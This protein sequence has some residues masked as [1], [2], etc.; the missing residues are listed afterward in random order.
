MSGGPKI[1]KEDLEARFRA[2]AGDVEQKKGDAQD[3]LQ[4]VAI[5]GGVL[6]LLLMFM[7]GNRRGK[8]KTTIVEVRRF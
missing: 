4:F 7:L 2:L 6:L 5:G 1:T 3:K 8:R